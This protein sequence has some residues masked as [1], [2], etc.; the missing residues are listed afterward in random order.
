MHPSLVYA[1]DISATP[2]RPHFSAADPDC[3][4]VSNRAHMTS[5]CMP[6]Q[7]LTSRQHTVS[8]HDLVS[9][10]ARPSRPGQTCIPNSKDKVDELRV[11]CKT[12]KTRH[13]DTTT[14]PSSCLMHYRDTQ[15]HLECLYQAEAGGARHCR[16]SLHGCTLRAAARCK[17]NQPNGS[18]TTQKQKSQA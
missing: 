4:V 11:L 1:V 15:I 12:P 18:R 10:A 17:R 13:R 7:H 14:V 8:K 3:N 6:L 5:L 9:A 16:I 2:C